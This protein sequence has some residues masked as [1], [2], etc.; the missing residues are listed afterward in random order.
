MVKKKNGIEYLMIS[1]PQIDNY[2]Y[3]TLQFKHQTLCDNVVT[4][5][6]CNQ[7][8]TFFHCQSQKYINRDQ[9][10]KIIGR[11]TTEITLLSF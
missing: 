5:S 9:D 1:K 8:G 6:F 2:N 3:K 11:K 10:A 7:S 4:P